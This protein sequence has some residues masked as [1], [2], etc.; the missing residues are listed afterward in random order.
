MKNVRTDKKE[1][2]LH[3]KGEKTKKEPMPNEYRRLL[4]VIPAG[5]ENA[6]TKSKIL[7]ALGKSQT[8]NEKRNLNTMLEVLND[9][10]HYP[11]GSS[12]DKENHGIFLIA[13]EEDLALN[14]RTLNSRAQK[15]LNRLRKT[16]DN[17]NKRDQLEFY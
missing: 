11:I 1:F 2:L 3:T 15:M 6:I 8:A 4:S 16:T 5:R 7:D 10:Y 13:D 14:N 9:R 17:F 12:S